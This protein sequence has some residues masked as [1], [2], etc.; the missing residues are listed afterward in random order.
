[1]EINEF[2]HKRK[3]L[4]RLIISY[5]DTETDDDNDYNLIASYLE[6]NK[7]S[8]NDRWDLKE[9]LRLISK[10]SKNH[11]RYSLFFRK[12]EKLINHLESDIKQTFTNSEIFNIFKNNKMILLFLITNK[13]LVIDDEIQNY[14]INKKCHFFFNEIKSFLDDEKRK[15]IENELLAMNSNI[16]EDFE[17]NQQT[18]ENDSYVC[19]LIRNDLIDEFI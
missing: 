17:K 16:F 10:I 14:L 11:Y 1:M 12:I 9:L 19:H 2:I 15:E 5:I 7:S 18:G 4:Y 3:E 8:S 13:F 6:N